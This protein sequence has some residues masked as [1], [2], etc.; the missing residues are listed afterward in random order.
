MPGTITY[1]RQ[2]CAYYTA[3][4]G[5]VGLTYAKITCGTNARNTDLLFMGQVFRS[6][7]DIPGFAWSYA[8]GTGVMTITNAGSASL[9]TGDK[10][11]VFATFK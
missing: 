10:I 3:T 11:V 7:T 2:F 9:T 4:S 5:D 1:N 6:G 8:S